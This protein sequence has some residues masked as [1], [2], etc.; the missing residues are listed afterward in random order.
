VGDII[1][2]VAREFSVEPD[3]LAAIILQESSGRFDACRLENGFYRK[4]LE[5]KE[6]SEL[7]GYIPGRLTL[8]EEKLLRSISYGLMQLMGNTAR[9]MGFTSDDW[10]DLFDP[11]INIRLG[12]KYFSK[13]LK[14]EDGDTRKALLRWNGGGDPYYPERVFKRIETR[15]VDLLLNDRKADA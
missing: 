8:L 2:T 5:Q 6:E 12:A 7:V 4:Y 14:S 3:I 13:L 10:Q 9:E 1:E 15:E 11:M